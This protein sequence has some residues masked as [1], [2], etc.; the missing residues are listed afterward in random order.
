[1]RP[2]TPLVSV[3]TP[4]YNGEKYLAECVDSVLSQTYGN[5][6]YT[7]VNNCSTDKTLEIAENYQKKD[8]RIKVISNDHFVA[9]IENHNI[10]VRHVSTQSEYCK[11]VSA[12][13]WLYPECIE[14]LV[15]LAEGSP[16]VGVVQSYVINATGV[17]WNGLPVNSPFEDGRQIAR[18]YL[19]SKID[20]AAPSANLYRSSFVRSVD[21]FFPGARESADVAACLNCLRHSDFGMVYQILSFERLHDE[22][23][24]AKSRE[25]DSYLLD[26]VELLLEYGPTFL[27]REEM[28][29]RL[30]EVLRYYYQVLAAS[31]VNVRGEDYWSY[32]RARLVELGLPFYGARL[33]KALISK[34]LDLVLNPKQTVE[35]GLRRVAQSAQG[36]AVCS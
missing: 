32:H 29:V 16:S 9:A 28:N 3:V 2:S 35:K 11:V 15:R 8:A 7:I 5:W 26:R 23:V 17:R 6:E 10:A 19:L 18:L 30:E 4:V 21:P 13:D 1:M 20:L 24:T 22:A 33:G 31:I 25:L 34:V 36:A 12:D 27:T 14:R